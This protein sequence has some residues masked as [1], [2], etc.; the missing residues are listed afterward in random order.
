MI[1]ERITV[2]GEKK[3]A[4]RLDVHVNTVRK[5]KNGGI[6]D[7]A[8][9]SRYGRITIYDLEIVYECLNYSRVRAGRRSAV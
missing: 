3:L 1:M 2:K 4:A 5:W 6:L 9:L 8:M 7:R